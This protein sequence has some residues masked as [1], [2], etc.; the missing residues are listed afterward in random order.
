MRADRSRW[1]ARYADPARSAGGAPSNWLARHL[2]GHA[3]GRA[4][5]LACGDG[6]NALYL[7]RQGLQVDA[8]DLAFAGLAHLRAAAPASGRSINTVQADLEHFR[9]PEDRYAVVVNIRYLQRSLFPAIRRAVIPGGIVVFETFLREQ[10]RLGH[11]KNPAFLLEPGELA[12]E[13]A[14]FDVLALEEGL[15]DDGGPPAHLARVVARRRL[16]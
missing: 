10:A 6:R 4:L 5:D 14:A 2:P 16:S 3:V 15:Y 7:A 1:E 8:I 13:F 9:L 12:R 11:P